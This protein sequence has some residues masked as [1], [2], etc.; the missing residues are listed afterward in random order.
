VR[1]ID[2]LLSYLLEHKKLPLTGLGT[3]HLNGAYITSGDDRVIFPEGVLVFSLDMLT[4]E[5]VELVR[6]ISEKTGKM[7]ALAS[8][9]LDSYIE[10]G[11]QLLNISK[12]FFIEGIGTLQK[13]HRNEVEFVPMVD[14]TLRSETDP[15]KEEPGEPVRFTENYMKPPKASGSGSRVLAIGL[16]SLLALGIL[17]WVVYYFYNNFS[18]ED[19]VMM[20]LAEPPVSEAA[21]LTTLPIDS[22]II[23]KAPSQD[24]VSVRTS[25]V[26]ATFRVVIETPKRQR[27]LKRYADLI[28]WGHKVEMVTS[29]SVTFKIS[30]PIKAPLSDTAYHRDSLGRFFGR[31]VWIEL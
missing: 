6:T 13:N 25:A 12:P 4:P 27:A 15:R 16:L 29:D 9:D 10:Q 5:D 7:K 19:K 31:K 28:E 30:F 23:S 11:K 21:R 18:R 3:F 1:V 8:A 22:T 17:G 20:A 26:P 2:I 14:D 24:S